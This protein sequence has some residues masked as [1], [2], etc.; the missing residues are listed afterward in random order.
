MWCPT[1]GLV[2][3]PAFQIPSLEHAPD[4][5]QEP[6]VLDALTEDGQQAIMSDGIEASFDVALN[7][8]LDTRPGLANL[9]ECGVDPRPGRKPWEDGLN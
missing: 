2:V 3:A 7:E 5:A 6:L 1:V 8:P 9:D 4:Q